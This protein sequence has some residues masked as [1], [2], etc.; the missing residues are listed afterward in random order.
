MNLLLLS[1]GSNPYVPYNPRILM[2]GGKYIREQIGIAV[3][4]GLPVFLSLLGFV[5]LIYVAT[6]L[7]Q[8]VFGH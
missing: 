6:S 1:A 4:F 5:L 7:I 2:E 8:S 3:N